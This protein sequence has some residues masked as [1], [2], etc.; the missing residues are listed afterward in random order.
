[1][2]QRFRWLSVLPAILVLIPAPVT[3]ATS[4][5]TSFATAMQQAADARQVPLSVIEA[6]AYVNT[7]WEWIN[8][9]AIDDGIGPMK[10]TPSQMALASSLSGHT[11]T[12][13]KGDLAANL[14]AGAALIAHYHSS[15]TD[16]GSWQP[17][18]AA[19][20]GPVVAQEIFNVMQTGASRT[21]STG[22]VI[23][24]AP[25]PAAAAPKTGGASSVNGTA[26]TAT[27]SPDYPS[28][29]WI[30][31]SSSNFTVAN[32]PT[33]YPID[34]I[35]I[36]DIEGS[37]GS[38]IQAFQDPNRA[39][40]AHYV[41]GYDGA[42]TQMVL[43]KDIAWH[44]GNWDYNTRAIGIEHAGFAYTPGLY[45]SAEYNQSAYLI[46][47]IC[48]KYGVPMDRTHAIGHYQVPDPDNPGLY[49]GTDHHTDPGPYW[50]W[51][52]YMSLAQHYALTL[53]SPP[54]M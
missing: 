34:M 12:E 33:D 23:T 8:T 36:H 46:A 43:E 26:T 22:E 41:I 19:T 13:I 17:A 5:N 11:E 42:I 31:A 47:T 45:T 21:T 3:A 16:L 20:Q 49:G 24:L 40:S 50:D 44:A 1:M 53:K 30:P 18:V 37:A 32:R 10:V 38:A 28:A 7:R 6:T 39:A 51:N 27:A 15:G 29:S 4:T 14:D 2:R 52:G 9:P 54:R 48:S 25:Q 35:V